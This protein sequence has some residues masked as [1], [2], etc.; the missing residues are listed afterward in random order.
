MRRAHFAVD[1]IRFDGSK[2]AIVTIETG[3]AGS[4][5]VVRVR[6]HRRHREAVMLLSDAAQ[7]ILEHDA[8]TEAANRQPIQKVRRGKL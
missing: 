4:A 7:I 6:A 5:P 1:G 2:Q 8:K 3:A